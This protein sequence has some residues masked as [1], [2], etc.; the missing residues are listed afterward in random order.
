MAVDDRIPEQQPWSW[1]RVLLAVVTW[2]AAFAGVALLLGAS[3]ILAFND[4]LSDEW[5]YA[6][7]AGVALVG[8]WVYLA[9]RSLEEA[10]SSRGARYSLGALALT[11]LVAGIA[12]ALN[13]LAHRYDDRV[14][15]TSTQRFSLAE[16]SASIASGLD[17]TVK[18]TA[19]FPSGSMEQSQFEDLMASFE[20]HTT[21]LEVEVFDPIRAPLKAKAYDI[22][23]Q[24]GT[25]V[26][27]AGDS[28]QR[29]ESDY[30]EEAFVNALVRLTAGTE[31][32]VCFTEGHG[33]LDP[34]EDSQGAGLGG[35]V[36][37]L[38]GQNYVVR[39]VNLLREG[40]VPE[41][42]EV[43]I[44][45]DPE[46]DWLPAERE[47]VARFVAGGGAFVLLL[48]PTHAPGL[49]ADMARYGIA[50]G[51]DLI[52]EANPNYQLVGGDASYVL[53]DPNSFD[54]HPVTE[55]IKGGV[56][57]R[58][59]RSV[60]KGADIAGINVQELA[61]TSEYGWAET[62]LSGSAMPEPTEGVDTIGNVP[63]M[64][65]AEIT[66]PEAIAL[67]EAGLA[68]GAAGRL[69]LP[70]GL[71]GGGSEGA[72]AGG[73][74]EAAEGPDAADAAEEPGGDDPEGPEATEATDAEAATE[75]VRAAGGRVV[76]VGDVDF[77][78]NELIDQV[79]NQDL[80]L[81][82][83]AWLVGEE[84]QISV[85]PNEAAQGTLSM[86]FIQGLLVWMLCL[87][88][89]PALAVVGALVTWRLRR[90]K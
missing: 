2:L 24:Y 52:L 61:R 62:D 72:A 23:S 43:L 53:L 33:E 13:V 67:G 32:T 21:L 89:M 40:G 4:A 5:K 57:L 68:A 1:A 55:A 86:S 74:P 73:D 7:V 11:V 44:A 22:T 20:D 39:K 45:A 87:F 84:D 81:N 19:F 9:R 49:A 82:T 77:A 58:L 37:K 17:Q 54:F 56:I 85:R 90:S 71:M 41:A 63:V 10:V 65:V 47:L 31:H 78:T 42:C 8:L 29:L 38:E 64:A 12:V 46:I 70:E 66:D 48:E 59:V 16:Q 75:V 26:L 83:V 30:G 25:V 60:A 3:A 80:L 69:G 6:G 35:V 88:V 76:V 18:V 36:I 51:D 14:D 50:V 34:D 15:L 28:K 27:E 79:S